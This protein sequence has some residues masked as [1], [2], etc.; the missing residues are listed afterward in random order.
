MDDKLKDCA[1]RRWGDHREVGEKTKERN[2][3]K[4]EKAKKK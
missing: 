1:K 2:K 3:E 4:T